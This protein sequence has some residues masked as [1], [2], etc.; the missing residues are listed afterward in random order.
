MSRKK[1]PS[2]LTDKQEA[3]AQH[4]A[5]NG[6]A[7]EAYKAAG[8]SW[9]NMKSETVR[10]RAAEVAANSTVSVRIAELQQ[11]VSER[12]L[13]RFDITADRILQE[14][15]AIAFVNFMDF[16]DVNPHSGEA[17]VDLRKIDRMQGAAIGTYKVKTYP[18]KGMD[19]EFETV[20]EVEFKLLDK[21]AALVDLGKHVGLFKEKV[22]HEH[23][24]VD[25]AATDFDS[26]LADVITRAATASNP[27]Q[28]N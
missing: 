20:K 9:Q 17:K 21:R 28:L 6:D 4:Y 2:G 25:D 26:R 12:A 19:G 13:K 7:I 23:K 11:R 27:Q 8:Y 22:Q 5:I 1:A 14:L 24:F 3:F 18:E 15:A 10:V 16:V